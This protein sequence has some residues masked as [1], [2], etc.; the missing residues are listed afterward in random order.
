VLNIGKRENER[1]ERKEEKRKLKAEYSF[2]K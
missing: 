1:N 2:G